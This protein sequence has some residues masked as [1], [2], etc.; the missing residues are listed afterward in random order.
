M[1]LLEEPCC[2]TTPVDVKFCLQST[3][4]DFCDAKGKA[5]IKRVV[6]FDPKI[7]DAEPSEFFGNSTSKELLAET[8]II[9]PSKNVDGNIE[10][11]MPKNINPNVDKAFQNAFLGPTEY[12]SKNKQEKGKTKFVAAALSDDWKKFADEKEAKKREE[13]Q[14]KQEKKDLQEKKK[15]LQKQ[16]KLLQE[17]INALT[18][19]RKKSK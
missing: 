11:L 9:S 6:R 2:S 3:K 13:E 1:P 7:L 14:K 15:E 4:N 12:L 19:S 5:R 10:E 18:K 17:Q 16:Q 8:P